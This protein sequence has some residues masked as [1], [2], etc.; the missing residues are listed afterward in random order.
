MSATPPQ[1]FAIDLGSR[2]AFVFAANDHRSAQ[3]L[4]RSPD[5]LRAIDAFCQLR[6]PVRAERL[7]LRDAT[8]SE[9]AIY[10]DRAEELAD[11]AILHL[12]LVH[13]GSS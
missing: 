9:A 12:L 5:L 7:A 11:D 2:P 1:I 3:R 6:D 10:L 4:M 13:I 8:T